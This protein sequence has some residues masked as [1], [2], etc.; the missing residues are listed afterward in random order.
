MIVAIDGPAGAGKS[1]VAR[2]L[3]ERLGFRYLDTGAMYRAVTWLAMQR[4]ID[5]GAGAALASLAA[6]EPVRFDDAGRV[7]IAGIDVTSSIRDQRVDRMVPVV[8]AHPEVREVMRERQR[9]LGR[10]GDV[11]I[12]GRDIGTVVAPNAEVKVYL[13][14]DRDVRAQR[15]MADRPGHRRGRARDGHA[16]AR[17][18]GR[19][20]DGA[21]AR[22]AGD[23]HDGSEGGGRRRADRGA[24]PRADG[25][26]NGVDAVWGVGRLTIGSAVRIFAP[27]RSYGSERMPQF[28]GVVLA[29]NHF[30]WLDPAAFGAASPRTIYYMAKI[31]A[32]RAPGLGELIRAFGTFAVRR[33]ESDREA[34]RRMREVVRDGK[35]LGIFAEGTRQLTGVPGP[36]QPGAAMAALQEDVPVVCAAI[37]GSQTWKVGNF[38]PGLDRLGR[39]DAVRRAPARRQGLPRGVG[40]DRA[41]AAPAVAVAGRSAR[42][43]RAAPAPCRAAPRL[44]GAAG[45]RH[46]SLTL[47][48][49]ARTYTE[50]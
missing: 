39:A 31:E 11:V 47:I 34:V 4:S 13:V 20:A 12:E 38:A 49:A 37:H 40:R 5:L 9:Q 15:R 48:P 6:A 3:A 27:L 21:G 44:G 8:A 2:A 29:M 25:R 42:R 1:T 46:A 24:R 18:E 17:Q 28:G 41:R 16:E 14:A 26:V 22:R 23:R 30:H 45:S 19:R 33:G 43:R 36:V 7:S 10:E 35:V 50:V 32:H